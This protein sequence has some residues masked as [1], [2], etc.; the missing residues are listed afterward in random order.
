MVIAGNVLGDDRAE[1][2][3]RVLP[4]GKFGLRPLLALAPILLLSYLI[5]ESM[6]RR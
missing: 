4:S 2:W 5:W 1:P 3:F 6:T